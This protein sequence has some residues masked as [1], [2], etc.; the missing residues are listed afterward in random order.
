MRALTSL[1][2]KFKITWLIVVVLI[3]TY[4]VPEGLR[5]YFPYG[6]LAA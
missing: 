3:V 2:I 6:E 4:L 5:K 1:R